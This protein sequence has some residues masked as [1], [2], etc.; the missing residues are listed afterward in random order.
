MRFLSKKASFC[1]GCPKAEVFGRIN[2]ATR[3]DSRIVRSAGRHAIRLLNLTKLKGPST[4]AVAE[5]ET[6]FCCK[7]AL[8]G[9]ADDTV[10]RTE[11]A[12]LKN[13]LDN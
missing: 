9:L 13:K 5:A 4:I 7:Q 10:T 2:E 11:H 12:E 6:P 3:S 8:I 1:E